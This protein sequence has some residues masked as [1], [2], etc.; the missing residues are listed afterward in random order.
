MLGGRHDFIAVDHRRRLG[1]E[2]RGEHQPRDRVRFDRV[3]RVQHR[4]IIRVPFGVYAPAQLLAEGGIA[5][6]DERRALRSS[7]LA[8]NL[9]HRELVG[10]APAG[11]HG[12]ERRCTLSRHAFGHHDEDRDARG[13]C[14]VEPG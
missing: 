2:A 6:A 9:E 11:A 13:D 8:A 5:R 3:P 12:F 14:L 4:D 1:G 7:R 10:L